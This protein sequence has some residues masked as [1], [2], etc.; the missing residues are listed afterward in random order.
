MKTEL[1]NP[2]CR[3]FILYTG[4]TIGMAP[5]QPE[6]PGSPLVPKPL[7]EL[8]RYV[9]GLDSLGINL[10]YQSFERPVDSSDLD[11]RDFIRM[12]TIIHEKYSDYDG[13]VILQGT[14]TLAYSASTLSFIFENLGKP[15]VITG[16]QLPISNVRTDAN[17]NLVNAVHIA[18]YKATMLPC[19]P[20]VVVVFA[21]KILRGCAT[22]KVSSTSLAGFDSPNQPPLGLIG[23]HIV[24]DTASIRK[25]P[26]AG[27]RFQINTVLSN[28]VKIVTL[29]PGFRPSHL[30]RDLESDDVEA[31][32]LLAFGA[33]NSPSNDAFLEVI[34]Q[35]KKI[36]VIA[37]QCTEAMVEMGLYVNS[38]TLLER[39]A[40]SALDATYEAVFAK[41]MW[42]LGSML[43]EQIPA[44]MQ[45]SQRGEQTV[46][47]FDVAYGQI[48]NSSEAKFSFHQFRT[49][50]ARFKADRLSRASIRIS[51][52]GLSGVEPGTKTQVR[53]FMN[54]PSSTWGTPISHDRC[55]FNREIE[56]QGQPISIIEEL[57]DTT[58]RS[59]LGDG[60]ITLSVVT[61]EGVSFWMSGLFLTLFAKA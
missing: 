20:E 13:F 59:C 4:G 44:Q 58:T 11:E 27:K 10:D 41:L 35:T 61:D 22:K 49:P 39:G 28:K 33:G 17:M 55:V 31:L 15:V 50:D 19:I 21:N 2:K 51:G 56:W 6:I 30:A 47:M 12:A 46:N 45:V 8:L 54:L 16:S 3:V 37:S 34:E 14:D 5:A 42:L 52:L 26:A 38:S 40:L 57:D 18:G 48:G 23:E 1:M 43:P 9:P 36:V 25:M 29:T 60:D 32:I 24:V 7:D 53:V